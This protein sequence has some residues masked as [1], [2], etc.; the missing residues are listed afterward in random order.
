MKTRIRWK[1]AVPAGNPLPRVQHATLPEVATRQRR[2]IVVGDIHGCPDELQRLLD[3]LSFRPG[4]DLLLSVGDLVNKGPDS[5][6]VLRLARRYGV[7][8]VRGNHD[9][10]ASAAFAAWL[11][12]RN[13]PKPHQHGWVKGLEA[14]SAEYLME[15]PFTL[16]LPA[17]SVLLVHAGLVP[18][19]SLAEQS[20]LDMIKMRDVLPPPEAEAEGSFD[21]ELIRLASDGGN[22]SSSSS[23]SSSESG[24]EG[25]PAPAGVRLVGSEN[26]SPSGRAWATVWS[27]P[28]HVLFGHDAMRHLQLCPDATGLD[29]GCVYGW[30]LT[31][32]VLP[33]LDEAGR[34]MEGRA[35]VPPG[36]QEVPAAK[37]YSD[38]FQELMAVAPAP[39]GDGKDG[40]AGAPAHSGKK[41]Q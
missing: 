18:G 14:A 25:R 34:V 26:P 35:H 1:L 27:G 17:Y 16:E 7:K 29:T 28:P 36:S 4:V 33:P 11:A 31:A 22:T 12:G 41:E 39:Q 15:L 9:E 23:S 19:V 21:W 20:M 10:S 8:A 40:A 32:L 24:G 5:A 13:I 30:E 38:K 3:R 37:V 6:E 2:V